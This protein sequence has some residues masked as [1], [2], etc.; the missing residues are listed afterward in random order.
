MSLRIEKLGNKAYIAIKD[1]GIGI[2]KKYHETIFEKF[3]Q[4]ENDGVNA[5]GAGLG[6]AIS[7]DIV[8]THKGRIWVESE[9]GK[10]DKFI[11]ACPF[12]LVKQGEEYENNISNRG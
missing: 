5:G 9:E 3:T 4:V 10:G 7:R 2:P 12:R 8:K 11:F 6:L 1:T